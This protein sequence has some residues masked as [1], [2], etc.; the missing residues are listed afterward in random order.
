MTLV[1]DPGRRLITKESLLPD[2]I[3]DHPGARR[4]LDSYGL[5]GCG[6]PQGPRESIE[7]FA[8]VHGVPLEKLLA[9]LE[10]SRAA[11]AP[12]YAEELGDILYRRFFRGAIVVILSAGATLGALLLALYAIRRSFTSLDLFAYV[13]AHANAQVFGWVGLFVM[14][15]AYQGLPRFKHVRLSRPRVAGLSFGLMAAGILLRASSCLPVPA[16]LVFGVSGGILEAATVSLFVAVLTETLRASK[17]RDSWDKYLLAGLTAFLVSALLEPLLY[18]LIFTSATP[19]ILIARVTDLMRP[20]RDLELLGFAGFVIL[21]VSQRIL[22]T[23]FGFR[24]AGR[25]AVDLAF[26]LLGSGLVLDLAAWA[27][28]RCSRQA[29][30]AAVSWGGTALYALG[31]LTIAFSLSAFTGGH[32]EPFTKFIR[33]AYGWLAVACVMIIAEPFYAGLI[34]VRFSHAYHGAIRHAFTVGFISLMI[35][36][37]SS[38]VVPI[39]QGRDLKELP[40]LWAPFLLVNTGNALRVTSQVATDLAPAA[41]FPLMG[42]SGTFEVLGFTLWGIHLWRLLRPS[43][44]TTSETPRT[45]GPESRV[46]DL[47]NIHPETLEVFDRFGFKELKNPILRNTLARRVTV[48]TACGLKNVNEDEFLSAL[49]EKLR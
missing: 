3:S 42:V 22:P 28:F 45:L 1:R 10:A 18:L 25:K 14:G 9:E 37:V 34:G 47:V 7:F 44:E 19:Q 20:F 40:G 23:A 49:R 2:V 35:L 4:V 33:A 39:L 24:Q 17:V 27:A 8:R 41:A 6:G 11:S 38:K 32:E 46:A 15:F 31:A 26:A 16:A 36:G 21:G 13:Q 43:P 12:A 30:W 48:R 5:Q 29:A